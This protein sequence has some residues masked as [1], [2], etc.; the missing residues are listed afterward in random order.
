MLQLTKQNRFSLPLIAMLIAILFTMSGV[1][2]QANRP[3]APPDSDLT[4]PSTPAGAVSPEGLLNPDGTLNLSTGFQ[5]ALDL[6]G[7][8]VILDGERG[9]VL[10]PASRPAVSQVAAWKALPN[11]GLGGGSSP[12]VRV[13]AVVDSDLYVGG[14]FTQT[15][16]GT[17]ANLGRIA[18]YDTTAGTWNALSNQG[19]GGYVSALAVVGSDLY[20]GGLF[21]Q[22]GDGT[23]TNLGNIA[24]Y[25]TTAGTWNALSNQGL[26]NTV[27]ELAVS[28]SDLYVGGYFSQTGDGTLTN[29]GCIA[30]Y[31]TTAGTW[32]ALPNQ[33]LGGGY[34]PMPSVRALAVVG[35]DLYVGGNF[36]RTGD[37]TLTNLGRIA[38]Y[39]TTAGTW[40]ALPNQGLGGGSDPDVYALAVSGSNLY[41][42]G[43]FTQTG[44]GTLTNLGR[45]AR[46][47]TTAGT[48]NAL[49]NQ[50]LDDRVSA[51]AM[52][53][54]DLYVGG[55]F[56]QTGD[57]TLTNLGRITR[58]DTTAGA[59][60]ALPNQGL[61]DWVRALAV[62]GSDLY[63]GG[64]FTQT[65]DGAL[66]N[67]GYIA[68]Y[69]TTAAPE[70]EIQV[71][72]GATDIPDGTGSINFGTTTVGMPINKTFTVKNTGTADLTL[73][74]P[75][76]VPAGF[77]VAS[78]F[79][80]TTLAPGN[81]TTFTVQLDAIAVGTYSGTLQFANNDGDE[82]PFDFTINGDTYYLAWNALPNQGLGG[83][84]D[85]DVYVLAV[86]GS[87]LYVGGRFTQTGD[88]TLTNLGSIA[89]Y[90]TTAG[91]W[92]ALPN[93]GLNNTVLEL[94][95][96]GSDLYV[97]GYFTQ[98]G[99]GTL[100]N[101]G[102]I[103]RYDTTAG[104]WNALPNQGLNN[105]VLELAVSGSD[106]YVGGYFSQTGDGTLTNLGC[107]TRYDTTAGTW[108]ALPNQGLGGGYLPMPSVSALAVVGSDLYVGG[109]FTRT[110]DGTLTN[111]GRIARYDTTAAPEDV[112]YSVC[113]PLVI[114][115]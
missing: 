71:L 78:S 48:W 110:G 7:W 99:D 101:L 69:D 11:Q 14:R 57:G 103:A 86:S 89:R 19:L 90:N 54:S 107:I 73:T 85:P 22:T 102:N 67:L 20:V 39:D 24:R 26:N 62:V 45:I 44:D 96:S 1:P 55:D 56:T 112:H 63:V 76:A 51:L 100:T 5:G 114:R 25:D 6:R 21:S 28:G 115:Q 41:V 94:A 106:L 30:R 8:E 59:W 83:G 42:G 34:L 60:N 70:P 64:D 10:K 84:S 52:S 46:Y 108:N 58:Y 35:S 98:T 88:G 105:T 72:D 31:D 15:G 109:N 77:S 92:N 74:E 75:I 16:D 104:T 65:G 93:Q 91:T 66:T 32:N 113:L 18:R 13:L 95:V 79:G 47:D 40:N 81:L 68:R 97:G 36:T 12:G 82:N 3:A 111:L 27:I 2:A 29:L 43:W 53:G 80:S 4:L 23:L 50:G 33:G 87:D 37:G 9:P 49:P 61:N 17:L 38:R